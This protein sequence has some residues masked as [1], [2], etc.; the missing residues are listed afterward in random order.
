[1]CLFVCLCSCR[2]PSFDVRNASGVA[3]TS[4]AAGV[5]AGDNEPPRLSVDLRK[6]STK[7]RKQRVASKACSPFLVVVY[8]CFLFLFALLSCSQS[9]LSR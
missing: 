6:R 8:C 3:L 9:Q 2:N 4:E 1:M 7:G 5:F